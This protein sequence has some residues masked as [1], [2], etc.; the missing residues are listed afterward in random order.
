MGEKT[1]ISWTNH[2]FNGWWGC[3]EVSPACDNCYAREVAARFN[4]GHWGKDAPR[5]F[6]GEKHWNDL[7]RWDRAAAKAGVPAKVFAFS[8][9]DLFEDRRDLDEWRDKFFAIVEKT[10]N[11]IY[12]FLTKRADKI[13]AMIPGRWK[14]KGWPENVWMGVTAENQRRW[15]E[16]VPILRALDAKVKWVSAEPLLSDI[17]ADYAGIDWIVVGGDS[18]SDRRMA[19]EWAN[20]ILVRCTSS[21]TKFFFKQKGDVLAKEMGCKS[22]A[23]KDPSEW[24]SWMRVQEFPE[25]A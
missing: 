7:F 18:G 17:V 22:K 11:L 19:P 2:T 12:Q 15:E 23:G 13:E 5:R 20:N 9:A 4:P 10:P 25:V 6:F 8:M 16:R 24:P 1:G 21:G 3:V 14:E